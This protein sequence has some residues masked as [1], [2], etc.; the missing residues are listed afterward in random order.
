MEAASANARTLEAEVEWFVRVMET[1]FSL[2]FGQES[3]FSDV[4]EHAPPH[5][6]SDDS[7]YARLVRHFGMDFDERI[8]LILSIIPHVRPE[9]LDMFFVNNKNFGRG[10]TEFGG[11]KGKVHGGFLP[12]CETASFVL[13]GNCLES[14]FRFMRMLDDSHYFIENGII[15]IDHQEAGEPLFAGMLKISGEYLSLLTSGRSQKPDFSAN[16]PAKRITSPLAWDDLVLGREV[17][18]EVENISAWIRHEKTIMKEWGLGRTVK[19]GY[20]CLF[21]GPPGTGKTLTATLIDANSG[22][23]V[24]RIDLSMVVSKYIGETEKNLA[25]IFD[26][27]KSRNWILFFDEADALFG[28]RTQASSSNDRY[29][30]QEVS[31][32][33]QRVEDFPGLVILATNLRANLDEAFARRF[34]SSIFFPLPDAEQRKKLWEGHFRGKRIAREDVDLG[35]IAEEHVL[36]GGAIANVVRYAAIRALN[37]GRNAISHEDL[38]KGVAKELIKEGKTV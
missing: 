34:Q 8:V 2:H 22:L 4:R 19:P 36:S 24:Y 33:L 18:D 13:N 10:F 9:A 29:A 32:L 3:A 31:Y 14:R 11:W 6:A 16:F 21:Y 20:R 26:Q 17:L 27:A 12:T 23:D 30:N 37:M 5:L 25:G 1:R 28:K 35:R 7:E 15:E 38:A